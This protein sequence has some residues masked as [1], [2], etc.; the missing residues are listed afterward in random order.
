MPDVGAP[1]SASD[2]NYNTTGSI[3]PPDLSKSG[4][5]QRRAISNAY[6]MRNVISN[7]ERAGRERNV[8]NA[9]IASKYNSEKPYR[10][11]SL[12][13]DGLGWK[14]NFSTKPLPML[15]NKVSPR[16]KK[17]LDAVKYLTNSALD[18]NKP[19]NALKTELFR[20]EITKLIRTRVG[21]NDFLTEVGMEDVL[22]GFAG[23]CWLDE[24]SWMPTFFRQD[25]FYVPSG[26]KQ[27]A[28]SAQVVVLR[29]KF[30][31]HELF[32]MIEDR[33][34]AE[35]AGWDVENATV[36]INKAMPNNRRSQYSSWE[37]VYEDLLREANV[38]LSH[39]SGALVISV[40]HVLAQEADGQVSHYILTEQGTGKDDTELLFEHEDQFESMAD[41]LALF[42]FEYGNGTLHGSKGIGREIYALAGMLDRARNEVVDRLNL[43]GKLVIQADE[44]ALRRFKMSVV[45]NA[46]LIGQG[47]NIQERKIEPAV[48]E[49]LQLDQFLTSLLDQM[50]GA[51][52]PRALEGERVTA[53]AVN[54]LA[55]R[56]EES[57]DTITGRYL[58]Q[59]AT[60]MTTM[61]KRICSTSVRDDDAKEFQKKMLQIMTREELNELAKMPV[62][63]TVA[64]YTALERQQIVAI[65]AENKGDPLFN[66]RELRRRTLT[67]QVNEE[68]ADAVLLPEEDPTVTAEQTRL[69][70]LELLPITQFA[71]AVPI[72][73]RD[74][75]LVHLGVMMP[76]MEQAAQAAAQDPK[77]V[78]ILKAMLQHAGG[79]LQMAQQTGAPKEQTSQFEQIIKKLGQSMQQI[80]QLAQAE[81]AAQQ[82]AEM[83]AADA[84]GIPASPTT[85]PEAV[86][87]SA[88]PAPV[89]A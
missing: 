2:V 54:L 35:A 37:R 84:E 48:E 71:T 83:H 16:L 13:S 36:A 27:Q 80:E 56:E 31:V 43:A 61:Q 39:E 82:A 5:I 18:D 70:M 50:A 3:N 46:L 77:G 10:Q 45:G 59:F 21:W 64:D 30:L 40:W 85:A 32:A 33:E 78:A 74:N 17:A 19:G 81:Q 69:Q 68:F 8:R 58:T 7:L 86:P 51:V 4:E 25:N 11:E 42:A 67:A 60:M 34:A 49:F 72:S 76:A 57:R 20:R 53:A 14:N 12:D 73:P 47:Y 52:T 29:Q 44:K 79:H 23:V 66:Q 9:R 38:G 65:G 55:G 28:N 24:Y 6:Q 41:C 89:A 88:P 87:G 26:T 63:E 1:K 62:A 75:H 22:F 15:V